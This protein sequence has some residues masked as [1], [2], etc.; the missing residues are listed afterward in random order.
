MDRYPYHRYTILLGATRALAHI[1]VHLYTPR[2]RPI[3]NID[4]ILLGIRDREVRTPRDMSRVTLGQSTNRDIPVL[5]VAIR[6]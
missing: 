3:T 4:M 6:V 2:F 5:S 1:E